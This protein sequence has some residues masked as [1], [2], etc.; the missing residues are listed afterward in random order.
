MVPAAAAEV[1]LQDY[2]AMD[3]PEAIL[4]QLLLAVVAAVADL[5]ALELPLLVPFKAQAA[6]VVL[7]IQ[8]H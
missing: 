2:T 4:Q 5:A 3:L 6:M 1:A 8:D 7:D